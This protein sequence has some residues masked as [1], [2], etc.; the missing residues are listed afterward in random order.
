MMNFLRNLFEDENSTSFSD[1][2][3]YYIYTSGK[4]NKFFKKGDQWFNLSTKKPVPSSS[5]PLLVKS[6]RLQIEK[7]NHENPVKIGTPYKSGKGKEYIFNGTSLVSSD[8]KQLSQA[9]FQSAYQK[10][11]Q[12]S[13]GNS[14]KQEQPAQDDAP[15]QD[16]SSPEAQPQAEPEVKPGESAIQDKEEQPAQDYTAQSVIDNLK[17]GESQ[18]QDQPQGTSEEQPK[19]S[20]PAP[21]SSTNPLEGLAQSIK[22]NKYAK[23]IVTLLSRGDK[24]GL[25]LA[26]ILLNNQV[27]EAIQI[28]NSLN[29]SNKQ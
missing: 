3:D 1:I 16:T 14:D 11:L 2:P 26:D 19:N 29:N 18:V 20:S 4:Q 23:Q 9:A 21:T 13:E 5:L 27:A 22:S 6:A 28:L 10:L 24:A 8:G 17:D 12:Q 15:V 25:V 7:Y